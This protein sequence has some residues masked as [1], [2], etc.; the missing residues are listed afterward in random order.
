MEEEVNSIIKMI[1]EERL[2]EGILF[3]GLS[4]F[5]ILLGNKLIKTKSMKII[6]LLTSIVFFIKG[7]SILSLESRLIVTTLLMLLFIIFG[8]T[9][10]V[11]NGVK[12]K[13]DIKGYL[14]Y[15]LKLND[16]TNK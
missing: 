6:A 8:L 13:D 16:K 12:N 3:V 14:K 5:I 2:F 7:M 15:K 1:I 10:A 4:L 11:K 9:Q